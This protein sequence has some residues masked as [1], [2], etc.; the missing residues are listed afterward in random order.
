[1][2]ALSGYARPDGSFGIRNHVAVVASV[3][4]ANG[5][6]EAVYR[7]LGVKRLTHTEGCGRGPQDLVNTTRTLMGLGKN[8][9][10]GAVLV[11]GLGCEFLKAPMIAGGIEE[12]KKRV[13][14]LVIQDNGGSQKTIEKAIALCR[15]LAAEL[16]KAER[17]EFPWDKLTIGFEC[18]GAGAAAAEVQ[19]ALGACADWLVQQGATVVFPEMSAMMGTDRDW[20]A[21]V[22]SPDVTQKITWALESR[23]R[24]AS[25]VFGESGA[26]RVTAS[27]G[28]RLLTLSARSK[29]E[30]VLDYGSAPS[31]KGL[32]L[33]DTPESDVF[34]VT[35][36]AAGGAHLVVQT[37]DRG[38]PAGFPILPVVKVSTSSELFAAMEDDLDLDAGR[39][40]HGLSAA[41][42]GKELAALIERV[43][44]GEQTKA[45]LNDYEVMAIHTHGPAF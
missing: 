8:P 5:V 11:V 24:T 41:D 27:L 20:S 30:D 6:V 45:E 33:M 34:S 31:K 23:N 40:A 4:C 13:E 36:L 7:E 19:R 32:Q 43:A 12:S 28:E 16:A 29:V 21:S 42:V 26:G 9:N 18:G 39:V 2:M 17:T 1:M 35:G 37:T 14:R 22:A 10:V 38:N 25:K 15:E 44:R 3:S